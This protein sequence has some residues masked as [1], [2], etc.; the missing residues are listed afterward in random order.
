MKFGKGLF[1]KLGVQETTAKQQMC[2]KAEE[3]PQKFPK[4]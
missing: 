1:M 4:L 3:V 2:Y